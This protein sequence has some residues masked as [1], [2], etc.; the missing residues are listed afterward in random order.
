M[1]RK[2]IQAITDRIEA[3]EARERNLEIASQN[4]CIALSA[5]KHS[6]VGT[7]LFDEV[8][9]I[10]HMAMTASDTDDLE[11]LQNCTARLQEFI[12]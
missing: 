7:P 11:G 8:V 3:H 12:R 4:L 6:T 2:I 1:I 10:G 9:A 5:A